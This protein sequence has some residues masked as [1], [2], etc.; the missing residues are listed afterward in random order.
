MSVSGCWSALLALGLLVSLGGCGTSG[1]AHGG[2]GG[3]SAGSAGQ[4]R[5]STGGNANGGVMA[6]NGGVMAS[7]GGADSSGGPS[8]GTD[9]GGAGGL[10]TGDPLLGSVAFSTPSQSFKNS[11]SVA[12]STALE[13]TEIRYT[14]DGSVPTASS[15]LYSGMPLDLTA[16]TQLRAQTFAAGAA[17]GDPS[18]AIFIARTFDLSSKLPIV[19]LDGYGSGQS[20]DKNVYKDAGVMIFEPVNGSA[21][22]VALP[23]LA[24][25]AGYHLRGQSSAMFPQRPYKVELRDSADADL[26]YPV[27]GMPADADWALIAPYYDRALIRNP[28]TYTLANEMGRKA[29]KTRFAEV[30]LNYE[31]RPIQESDYQGIYWISETIKINKNRLDL[32]KLDADDTLLPKVGGGYVF[33]FDQAATDKTAPQLTC[34]T[35]SGIT[36]WT[37]CE[38]VDPDPMPAPEQLAWLT[39]YVQSFHETLFASPI[40]NYAEYADVASFVDYLILSE[41]TRNV[42][43]YV[44]SAFFHKDRDGLLQGGPF[45]D[46]NFSLGVG[47]RTTVNPAPGTDDGGW[48]YQGR[49]T[50]S[51]PQRNVNSWFPKLMSDPAFVEQ[52]KLRWKSLRSGLLSQAALEQRI[53]TLAGQLDGEA[54]QRDFAKWP[55]SMV[56]PDGRNGIVYGPSAAT[57]QEQLKAMQ[58]FV[59]ARAA[60]M[61]TQWQ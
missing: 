39:Q 20:T 48:Q 17:V 1:T 55:V 49:T 50:G 38:I 43:S 9:T 14:T 45:W 13:G 3:Q 27:L 11:L 56:L 57:W 44:R 7:N 4:S 32:K 22:L 12:L 31:N 40:G 59:V 61:D 15:T 25:R 18:T 60:W 5:A 52:V 8:G 6:S 24:A 34:A 35:K 19:L 26:K 2:S 36:C 41:L 54:V 53:S 10:A 46:Y 51:L 28:F 30:Y 23:T 16:T 29:P 58:D 42:D 21:S 37:D 33:K 47:G